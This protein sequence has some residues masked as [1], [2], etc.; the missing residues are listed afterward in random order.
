MH[1]TNSQ[2]TKSQVEN[3]IKLESTVI[4]SK[5]TT[6]SISTTVPLFQRKKEYC[7]LE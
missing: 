5:K 2:F 7:N 1:Y 4:V 3:I 6:D